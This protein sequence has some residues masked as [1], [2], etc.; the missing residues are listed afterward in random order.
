MV[1]FPLHELNNLGPRFS[2]F[3]IRVKKWELANLL[4]NEIESKSVFQSC[5]FCYGGWNV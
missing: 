1:L 2:M 5:K 3:L 4:A